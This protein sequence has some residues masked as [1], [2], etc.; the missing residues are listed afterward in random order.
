MLLHEILNRFLRNAGSI[1][2]CLTCIF[3]GILSAQNIGISG[4]GLTPD[5]SAILDLVAPDK[6]L[7][8]PRVPLQNIRDGF[9]IP[10]PAASLLVY[11][12]NSAI[13]EGS[14][15]GYYYNAGSPASPWWVRLIDATFSVLTDS[16]NNW[17]LKGNGGTDASV[18]FLG[19]TDANALVFR[20]NRIFSGLL[21]G[22]TGNTVFGVNGL[23]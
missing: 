12:T 5:Q 16:T 17:K 4:N 14:G 11:N 19:T 15:I 8:I 20:Y 7:L 2:I 18:N 22:A 13:V 23:S 9:T 3:S 10:Q 21:D 6:G 1:A